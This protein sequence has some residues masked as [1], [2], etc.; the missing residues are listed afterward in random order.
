MRYGSPPPAFPD[1]DAE[2]EKQYLERQAE[3]L[4]T[5]LNALRGRLKGMEEKTGSE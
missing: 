2:T 3:A 1:I 5:Q 4:Q